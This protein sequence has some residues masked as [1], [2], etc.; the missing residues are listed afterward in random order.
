MTTEVN[1]T[2]FVAFVL[3]VA[4]SIWG[5]SLRED[6]FRQLSSNQQLRV[7]DK[8]PNYTATET[9]PFGVLLLGLVAVMLFRLA[10]LKVAFAI[11]LPAFLFFVV[12][13][14]WRTRR[15]FRT[16]GLPAA[17]LSQYERSRVVTYSAV[18]VPLALIAWLIYR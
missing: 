16:S 12:A 9:I 15:R 8:M 1:V 11:F 13:I 4:L 14:H 7:S 18:C 17:F 10:W 5:R 3:G 6:A 2:T